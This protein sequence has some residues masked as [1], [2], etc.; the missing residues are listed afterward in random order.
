MS[1]VYAGLPAMDS[2]GPDL[3][4]SDQGASSTGWPT[5]SP[6]AS[7]CGCGVCGFRGPVPDAAVSPGGYLNLDQ[8]GVPSWN[9]KTSLTLDQAVSQLTRDGYSWSALGQPVTLTYAFRATAP[10]EIGDT[11]AGGFVRFNAQQIRQT[12]LALLAWSDVSGVRFTRVG[13]GESLESAYSDSATILFGNFSTGRSSSAGFAFLPGSPDFSLDFGDVWINSREGY[14]NSPTSFNY[15]G[16]TLTHEIGHS[17]GLRH[18]SNYNASSNGN[19]TYEQNASYFQDSFQYTVMSYFEERETGA[20]FRVS[21]PSVPLLDD[22]AA[23]QKLYGPNMTTRTGDTVYG[24][25]SNADRPWFQATT[26]SSV[27]IWAVWD[28]GGSDTFNF[29]GYSANLSLIHI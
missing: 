11:G 28:A 8:R 18:P 14:N 2:I 20:D 3:H 10:E 16:L 7:A 24:F 25:S 1:E 17:I 29:S 22:I 5:F 13:S 19:I 15:G 26:S 21:Y 4:T 12:E 6:H 23:A 9:G 27:M